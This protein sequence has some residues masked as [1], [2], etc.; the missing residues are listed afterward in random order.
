MLFGTHLI[1]GY[2]S[3]KLFEQPVALVVLG[4][5]LPDI[6]DKPLGIL[7]IAPH[8]HSIGHS[9]FTVVLLVLIGI[10]IRRLIPMA[11]GW[12]THIFQDALHILINRGLEETTFMF[13]PLMFPD[14][15]EITNGSVNFIAN[16]WS[17]YLWTVGFYTEFMF[18]ELTLFFVYDSQ[19]HG[20]D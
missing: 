17:N 20:D 19:F 12:A 16:F 8:Y 18:W 4:A 13:Y 15:P 3:S 7:E 10:R 1:G 2:V 5:A 11:L 9:I 6:I 14:K